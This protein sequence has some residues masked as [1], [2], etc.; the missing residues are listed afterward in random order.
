MSQSNL[1][2]AGLKVLVV[3]DTP[4]NLAI[5]RQTLEPEG[6]KLFFANSGEKAL[7]IATKNLPDLILLDVMMPGIDGFETCNRLKNQAETKNIPIIFVTAKT[8]MEDIIEGF[9][10]GGVDYI[11]KPFQQKEVCVR[12]RTHLELSE[13]RKNL[14][15]KVQERT[16]Q[17]NDSR[18]EIVRRLGKAAE[19]KD[20]ETGSHVIRMSQYSELLG[21]AYGM[22]DEE[23]EMLLNASPMHDVGKIGIPDRVLLKP[24]KLN[25]EE[26]EIMKTHAEMGAEILSE[27]TSEVLKMSQI[28]AITH[29]E[30]WDGSGYPNGLKGK[31]IPLVG[32]IVTIADVFDALT[33]E[34]PYKKAWSVEDAIKVL[35]EESGKH[36]DPS[37][38]PLFKEIL[39]QV[40]EIKERFCEPEISED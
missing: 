38:V 25:E 7:E 1:N 10:K 19:F 28:V 18:L 17:L 36:F 22:S 39:P 15:Q 13:L 30:R 6:Y 5:L 24:G 31:E 3:D 21:K 32:R 12:V 35:E 11:L 4:T 14:E 40:L 9:E 37:L 34:R 26:W 20:N 23:C 2:L 16:Q 33:S 27:G 8:E 29:H